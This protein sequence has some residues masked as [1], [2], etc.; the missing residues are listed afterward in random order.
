M[1]E[2]LSFVILLT[3]Y[4][5]SHAFT[6][7]VPSQVHNVAWHTNPEV[8]KETTELDAGLDPFLVPCHSL[9]DKWIVCSKITELATGKAVNGTIVSV[10]QFL[11]KYGFG[12]STIYPGN[13]Q[14]VPLLR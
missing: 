9:E 3:F 8:C 13:A 2:M 1:A 12:I 10:V 4:A 7:Y 11:K 14:R 5:Y 6:E